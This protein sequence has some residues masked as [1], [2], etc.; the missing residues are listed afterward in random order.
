VAPCLKRQR[1]AVMAARTALTQPT[2]WIYS[3]L[4][5]G[6]PLRLRVA[7]VRCNREERM[8]SEIRQEAAKGRENTFGL[9]KSS[10]NELKRQRRRALEC[11]NQNLARLDKAEKKSA[12][13]SSN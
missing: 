6:M 7:I 12:A 1:L 5:H 8:L 2:Y 3:P 11:I 4:L 9:M 13:S 10:S